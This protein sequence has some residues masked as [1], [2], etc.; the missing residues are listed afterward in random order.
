MEKNIES[1]Q[2]QTKNKLSRIGFFLEMDGWLNEIHAPKRA[3]TA[4]REAHNYVNN[5][6]VII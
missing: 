5:K 6:E 4:L 3:H 1:I 2:N